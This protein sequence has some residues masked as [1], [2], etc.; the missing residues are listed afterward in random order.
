MGQSDPGGQH[1]SRVTL[2]PI[3]NVAQCPLGEFHPS[4]DRLRSKLAAS[5]PGLV[6]QIQLQGETR[7]PC[8]NI[9]FVTV[10]GGTSLAVYN[11]RKVAQ[12]EKKRFTVSLAERCLAIEG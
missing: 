4:D 12:Y 9:S 8:A 3:F 10:A 5:R 1:K 6:A 11:T 7:A 2:T